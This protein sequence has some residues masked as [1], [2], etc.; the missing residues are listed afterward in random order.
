M[1]ES[2][3]IR[4][5]GKYI[6]EVDAGIKKSLGGLQSVTKWATV[7]AGT[8]T[9]AGGAIF[10]LT[11]KAAEMGDTFDKMAGRVGAST[12]FL[13]GMAH[14]AELGGASINEVEIGMRRM[15]RT[16]SDADNGLAT[17]TRSFEQLGIT[18]TDNSGQLKSSEALFWEITEALGGIESET[19]KAAL[20]QELFGRSGTQLLPMLNQGAD[21]IRAQMAEAERLG[22]V[23]TEAAAKQSADFIDAQTRM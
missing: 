10:A 7:I 18:V 20:A 2:V 17:A 1:D 3:V 6:D 13:S 8:A 15:A 5:T 9:A 19:K 16:A 14:A 12:E 4:I 22:I 21:A 11:K 23:Y